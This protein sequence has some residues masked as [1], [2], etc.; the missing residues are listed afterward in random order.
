MKIHYVK[1]KFATLFSQP[2]H[3][4]HVIIEFI[5]AVRKRD[6][7]DFAPTSLRGLIC[8]FNRHVKACECRCNIVEDRV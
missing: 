5:V 4:S 2:T 3:S 8:S 6:G 7:K 1:I